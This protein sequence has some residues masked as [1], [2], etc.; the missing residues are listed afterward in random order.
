MHRSNATTILATA[1]AALT[2]SLVPGLANAKLHV[3]GTLPDFADIATELGGD[4]VEAEALILGTEDPH[5]VDAKPSHVL[6]VNRADLLICIGLGLE[7]GWLPVLLTQSRNDKVQV[8]AAGYLD[9]SAH[10]VAKDVPSRADRAM[11]DVHGGGNPHYYTSP[12]EMLR[13]AHAIHDKL[14]EL[15]PDG[16]G[17][18]DER[19]RMFEEK[20][21]EREAAWKSALAPLV[22]TKVVVYHK[23]WVYLLDWLAFVEVGA[24][25]PKPGI[26]PSPSHVAALLGVVKD[27]HV[28][29]VFQEIY[30]PD[31]LS[32]LFAEKAGAK[33]LVLPSMVGAAPGIKTVWDKWDRIVAEVHDE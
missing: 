6:R 14:V 27:Q 9:A 19:W 21:R 13:V 5:F 4:R 30:H 23:S 22:G 20:F 26:P 31:R 32:K 2:L 12:P 18:Y 11:G 16:R 25:E 7:G 3:V 33:L 1:L 29:F 15:D 24:L 17:S 10:I 28:R 8:G